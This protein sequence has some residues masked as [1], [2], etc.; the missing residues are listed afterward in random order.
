MIT[1]ILIIAVVLFVVIGGAYKLLQKKDKKKTKKENVADKTTE[2]VKE[3]VK[4]EVKLDDYKPITVTLMAVN[5][6]QVPDG[7]FC[8]RTQVIC[9][10]VK[11]GNVLQSVVWTVDDKRQAEDSLEFK[12]GANSTGFPRDAVIACT[13]SDGRTTSSDK[14]KIVCGKRYFP[15]EK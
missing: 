1:R 5:P 7:V 12:H 2:K 4:E 14:K 8:T 10:S 15:D 9:A 11:G 3:E 13:V 6:S